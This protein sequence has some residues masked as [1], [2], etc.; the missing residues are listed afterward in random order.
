MRAV[1]AAAAVVLP[2]PER[3]QA[4]S[5]QSCC[6]CRRYCRCQ[7]RRHCRCHCCCHCRQQHRDMVATQ[8]KVTAMAAEATAAAAAARCKLG[9]VGGTAPG[10]G[11]GSRPCY[12]CRR[13]WEAPGLPCCCSG[14]GALHRA[15]A[16]LAGARKP[17]LGIEASSGSVVRVGGQ[18]P[19]QPPLWR[20]AQTEAAVEGAAAASSEWG[21]AAPVQG[22]AAVRVAAAAAAA[23]V[24]FPLL[25]LAC[26]WYVTVPSSPGILSVPDTCCL[27]MPQHT[28][29]WWGGEQYLPA[30]QSRGYHP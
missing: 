18:T 3:C 6:R 16:I 15:G 28:G 10:P 5:N 11:Q 4:G 2:P 20:P 27:P 7:C 1:A 22:G 19:R 23:A 30:P 8:V 29:S 9:G 25:L 14:A 21:A 17:S 24:A 26:P 13:C 12:R